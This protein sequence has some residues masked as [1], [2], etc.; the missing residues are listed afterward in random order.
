M[1][2][3]LGAKRALESEVA[4]AKQEGAGLAAQL[5]VCL[6]AYLFVCMLQLYL[7]EA[8]WHFAC[9]SARASPQA[10]VGPVRA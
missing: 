5:Q 3:L 9:R 4:G 7:V 10:R 8:A 6:L 2:E 1:R